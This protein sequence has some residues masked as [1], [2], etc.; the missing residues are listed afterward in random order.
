MIQLTTHMYRPKNRTRELVRRTVV[1]TLMAVSL[2]VLLFVL[3]FYMLGYQFDP[4]THTVWQTGLVQYDSYPRNATVAV[5]DT[6]IDQTQT[7]NTVAPGQH[8]FS[9]TLQGYETWR[10]TLHIQSNTVTNLN[11]A[12]LVPTERRVSTVKRFTQ[13][14][15]MSVAP[16]GRV[17]LAIQHTSSGQPMA[18]VGDLTNTS[19]EKFTEAELDTTVLQGYDSSST[20]HEYSFGEWAPNSRYAL[21]KHQYHPAGKP[22]VTQW[23]RFDR[24]EPKKLVDISKIMGFDVKQLSFIGNNGRELYALQQNGDLRHVNIADGVISRP[25]IGDIKEFKLYGSDRLSY[26][27]VTDTQRQAGIWKKDWQRPRV[28]AA[29]PASDA[30]PLTVQLSR[31]FNKD[32]VAFGMGNSLTIYRGDLGE[33][34]DDWQRFTANSQKLTFGFPVTEMLLSDNGRFILSKH[35]SLLRSYDLERRTQSQDVQLRGGETL[36]WFDEFHFWHLDPDGMVV[37]REFDGDNAH[38]L[39]PGS[40]GYDAALSVDQKFIYALSAKDGTVTLSKLAMKVEQ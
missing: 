3:T 29:L 16:S 21:I 4:Q 35:A 32:T 23:L 14:K 18:I 31:Y 26:I 7:K 9:M 5:D 36:R 22:A 37:M 13:P 12:R 19:S 6:V 30:S 20:H 10:K 39:L 33:S 15:L 17:A 1:Y 40:D 2:F 24:Q 8:Q 34:D 28:V 11:Y 27:A 38:Q 25:L